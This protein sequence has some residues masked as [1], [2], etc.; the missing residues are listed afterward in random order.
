MDESISNGNNGDLNSFEIVDKA[1]VEENPVIPDKPEEEVED[2][3]VD[4]LGSG[5]I[6]KKR[7]GPWNIA[8]KGTGTNEQ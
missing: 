4:I 2:E 6:K 5:H 8:T 7:S 1:D 3:W